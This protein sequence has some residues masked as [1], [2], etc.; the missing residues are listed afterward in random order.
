MFKKIILYSIFIIATKNLQAQSITGTVKDTSTK[1]NVKNAVVALLTQKDSILKNFS[2]VKEDGSFSLKNVPPGKYILSVTHPNFGEYVDD[3]EINTTSQNLGTIALTSKSKLLAA[4]I[5]KSGSPIR[6]KGDTTIYTADSFKVSAN[7][8][9]E[10]LLKKM[11]GI[12]VD[13]NG[14]IKAMGQKVEKIL[15]DGEE[16]FG[17]DPGMAVKNL[18]ADAIKEVQ[19]FDKKSDQAEFTGIDDGKTKKTINLKL[20]EDK[21]KGYFGKIDLAAGPLKNND[22]RFNENIMVSSFKGKRKISGYLLSGNTGQDGLNWQ[23]EQKFGSN[24]NEN[25]MMNDDG[26]LNFNFGERNDPDEEIRVDANNGFITNVNAGGQYSNKFFNKNTLNF[27]PKYNS[28]VYNNT[29]QVYTQTQD[30]DTSLQSI[31]NS[32]AHVNRFNVKLK[33]SYDM[34]IDSANT[35]K[36]TAKSNFYNTKSTENSNGNTNGFGNIALNSFTKSV[37]TDSHKEA[38]GLTAIFKHK[39]KKARRTF[40]LNADWNSLN[41]AGDNFTKSFNSDFVKTTFTNINQQLDFAKT[42][43][44]VS[45]KLVYTEPLTKKLALEIGYQLGLNNGTNNQKI[46]AF[47]SSTGLYDIKIDSLSNN[48]KQNI[49]Q[50][51]PSAKINYAHKKIKANIGAAASIS[52]YNLTDLAT[53][54]TSNRNY[55]NFAPTFNFSYTKK[56]NNNF[57]VNYNGSTKQPTL[58]QLQPLL[59]NS[60]LF[61]QT[62]GN[63][64]LKP[65]FT[66]RISIN[67]FG[68]NFVKDL[69]SYQSLIFG[70]EKN[71]IA[72]NRTIQ[73]GKTITQPI[74]TNGNFNIMLLAG[75]G[76]KMKKLNTRFGINFNTMFNRYVD[77]QNSVKT[78]SDNTNVGLNVN[79]NKSKDKKYDVSINLGSNYNNQKTTQR[80]GS[81]SY[82]TANVGVNSTIYYKKVWS[83]NADYDFNT[84]QKTA[85]APGRNYNILNAKLQRTFKKDEY[86]LYFSVRDIFNQNIGLDRSYFGT[87]FTETRNDR[88]Q[89]Y[90]MVGFAWNFKNKAVAKK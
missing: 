11:P 56:A 85:Q 70:N 35:L 42:T 29:K 77:Y 45:S 12:Q 49:L 51:T 26:G 50:H 69:W 3:V 60:N 32:V 58:N 20:K 5:I 65:S 38:Y 48:F 73:G 90:F 15:V 63:P 9:V 83:L 80:S 27:S 34:K 76:F 66:N 41:S 25:T 4:V 8:N 53:N 79:I 84:Q 17:D 22:P 24:D 13:K 47:N 78:L 68:Y 72:N 88:L 59:N 31:N 61:N 10:E 19:V 86:T 75:T 2:R 7:A 23:D 37:E 71:A 87:S 14:E 43:N 64:N 54:I 39:F 1:V 33:G 74:N 36:I 62:I 18:R 57:S 28:Q 52:D 82:S 55:V 89:R 40:S 46:L 44:S 21:K 30:K 67:K 16:F 6:I 81:N